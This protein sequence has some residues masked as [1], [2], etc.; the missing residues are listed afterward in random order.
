MQLFFRSNANICHFLQVIQFTVQNGKFGFIYK[1]QFTEVILPGGPTQTSA[2]SD[3]FKPR[4]LN[5]WYMLHNA[6]YP[7]YSPTEKG[8]SKVTLHDAN[9]PY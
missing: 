2:S 1:D 4:M 8:Y 5:H 6:N 9:Y 3:A 7:Y